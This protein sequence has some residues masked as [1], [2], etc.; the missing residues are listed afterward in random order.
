MGFL[1]DIILFIVAVVLFG[2]VA[3]VI[4]VRAALRDLAAWVTNGFNQG[5]ADFRR[6][7]N[8]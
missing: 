3:L 1:I 8:W 2:I 7:A 6:V 5:F 4:L